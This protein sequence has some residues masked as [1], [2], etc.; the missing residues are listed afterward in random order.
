MIGKIINILES[1]NETWWATCH[2]CIGKTFPTSINL[3]HETDIG[4][5]GIGAQ[6]QGVDKITAA[7]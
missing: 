7:A 2:F 1:T 3:R 4:R 5:L 6:R